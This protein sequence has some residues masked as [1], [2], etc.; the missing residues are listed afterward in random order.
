MNCRQLLKPQAWKEWDD[1]VLDRE[2]VAVSEKGILREED[3]LGQDGSTG[4]NDDVSPDLIV[5]VVVVVT[6]TLTLILVVG[7]GLTM[8]RRRTV[9]G[10]V[11]IVNVQGK[12]LAQSSEGEVTKQ[13]PP[14]E[15]QAPVEVVSDFTLEERMEKHTHKKIK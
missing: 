15:D 14:Q 1:I 10:R 3:A 5:A 13:S 9:S 8:K 2:P 11:H 6:L 12:E 4:R 7:A